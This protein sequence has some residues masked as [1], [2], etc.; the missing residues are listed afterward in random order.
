MFF[1]SIKGAHYDTVNN[2]YGID[3]NSSG[4]VNLFEIARLLN[5]NRIRLNYTIM[6]VCFDYEVNYLLNLLKSGDKYNFLSILN[7]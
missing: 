7:K 1:I 4:V 2:S 3:D 6:F 5:L